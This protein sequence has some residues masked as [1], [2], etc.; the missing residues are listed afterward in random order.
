M[1]ILITRHAH[2]HGDSDDCSISE[3]V[4]KKDAYKVQEA[5]FKF[6]KDRYPSDV[7]TGLA[8]AFSSTLRAV[9]T[10][11]IL[12]RGL[13]YCDMVIRSLFITDRDRVSEA[14]LD[15]ILLDIIKTAKMYETEIVVIAAHGNMPAMFAETAHRFVTSKKIQLENTMTSCGYLIDMSGEGVIFSVDPRYGLFDV[16]YKK[17]KKVISEEI[18]PVPSSI[19]EEKSAK[20]KPKPKVEDV[21]DL[22]NDIPF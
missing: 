4:G 14:D 16:Q 17:E 9:R 20:K 6:L 8:F 2:Y 13:G 10:A 11:E 12:Q 19:V 1:L 7:P 18:K 3:D 22:D 5:F 15:Q 21:N